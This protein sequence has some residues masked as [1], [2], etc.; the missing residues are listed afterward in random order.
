MPRSLSEKETWLLVLVYLI[1][2]PETL[3]Q[4]SVTDAKIFLSDQSGC[5][6]DDQKM[7]ILILRGDRVVGTKFHGKLL[8]IYWAILV[9]H[10]H[11]KSSA[12]V[13]NKYL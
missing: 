5:I 12:G 13:T 1:G 11:H 10:L 3:K 7:Y 4:N 9:R 8:S 6:R 2:W